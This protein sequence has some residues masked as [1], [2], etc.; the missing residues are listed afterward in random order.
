M[1]DWEWNPT[2]HPARSP[3]SAVVTTISRA[4]RDAMMVS[5][6]S[7]AI[8]ASLVAQEQRVAVPDDLAQRE[9]RQPGAGWGDRHRQGIAAHQRGDGQAELVE[10]ASR[11]ELAQPG[12]AALAQHHLVAEL[13]QPLGG[14]LRVDPV[15]SGDDDFSYL[16]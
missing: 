9:M 3:A 4:S 7:L 13:R 12:G 5:K 1:L 16:P 15:R 11:D 14:L 10:P 8:A 6:A 2:R